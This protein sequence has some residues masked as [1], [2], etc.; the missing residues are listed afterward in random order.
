MVR[1]PDSFTRDKNLNVLIDDMRDKSRRNPHNLCQ[2]V[3]ET[4]PLDQ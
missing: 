2:R 3:D 4:L 1:I